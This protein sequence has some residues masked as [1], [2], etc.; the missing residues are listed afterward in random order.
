VNFKLRHS[1]TSG[2]IKGWSG[3]VWILKILVP[4]SFLTT[5]LAWSGWINK[6]DFILEPVMD[7]I[8]LPPIAALPLIVGL[9]TGPYGAMAAVQLFI[10]FR[11][12]LLLPGFSRFLPSRK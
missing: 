5:L 11:M 3:F 1:L 4:I 9:L 2:I 10:I 12:F 7:V 8:G 6:L